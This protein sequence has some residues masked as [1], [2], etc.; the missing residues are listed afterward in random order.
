MPVL[1]VLVSAASLDSTIFLPDVTVPEPALAVLL[2]LLLVLPVLMS[3]VFS[4][5]ERQRH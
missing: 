1:P 4:R 5:E 3:A 2:P